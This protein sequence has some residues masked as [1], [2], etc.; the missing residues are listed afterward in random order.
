MGA[1]SKLPPEQLSSVANVQTDTSLTKNPIVKGDYTPW[2]TGPAVLKHGHSVSP[3]STLARAPSKPP[4]D[5]LVPSTHPSTT[6]TNEV[7][8][9]AP[10]P[11]TASALTCAPG[12]APSHA[13]DRLGFEPVEIAENA[14]A[15]TI[16]SMKTV[17]LVVNQDASLAHVFMTPGADGF[18]PSQCHA[19]THEFIGRFKA[20][21]YNKVSMDSMTEAFGGTDDVDTKVVVEK[22]KGKQ[23]AIT[24]DTEVVAEKGKQQPVNEK[25][26]KSNNVDELITTLED[27][28]TNQLHL[29]R[30]P[31]LKDM[32]LSSKKLVIISALPSHDS[33]LTRG[34]HMFMNSTMDYLGPS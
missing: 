17:P 5:L 14:P 27:Q 16:P 19:D 13:L 11:A 30:L 12:L 24:M 23:H 1:P 6:L 4:P 21:I 9:E 29:Q 32:L 3:L 34:K 10:V 2:L 18:F 25:N 26:D 33:N 28:S 31:K 15:K 7:A 20:H 22:G 8:K